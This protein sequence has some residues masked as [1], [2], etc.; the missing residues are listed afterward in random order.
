MVSVV[1]YLKIKLIM[2]RLLLLLIIP[3]LSYSQIT[4][5]DIMSIDSTDSFIRLM[6][7]SGYEKIDDQS[8]DSLSVYGINLTTDSMSNSF[9]FY[10]N[11]SKRYGLGFNRTTFL[12]KLG[13]EEDNSENQYDLIVEEIKNQCM[14]YEIINDDNDWVTYRCLDSK[15]IGVVG[16]T[17]KDGWGWIRNFPY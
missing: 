3:T 13:M 6:I 12:T 10:N 16:F 7:E 1:V 5:E 2:K 8:N 11:Y 17:I 4:F 15:Y 9:C 14:Y